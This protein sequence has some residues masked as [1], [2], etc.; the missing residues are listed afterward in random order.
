[1]KDRDAIPGC[2]QSGPRAFLKGAFDRA[3]AAV[4]ILL[5]LLPMVVVAAC[6]RIFMGSPV[7]FCNPRAGRWGKTFVLWKFKTMRDDRDASGEL[8]SDQERL[9]RLGR[10]LRSASLD[11]L[12]QLWNVLRGDMSLVGPR[13]LLLQYLPLYSEQQRR[14]HDVVPGITGWAQVNGRNA[15]SWEKK[16]ELDVW[17]VDHWSLLLDLRILFMTAK[18]V[19]LRTGISH[20]G[21]ATMPFFLGSA[22]SK[23]TNSQVDVS[24]ASMTEGDMKLRQS[25]AAGD[26]QALLLAACANGEEDR[27]SALYETIG[28]EPAWTA[29]CEHELESH[30]AHKLMQCHGAS[31]VPE[32]WRIAHEQVAARIGAYMS[33]L[34]EMAAALSAQGIPVIALK[35]AGIARGIYTCLGCSPMGDLDT[36]VRQSDFW[37]AHEI[38]LGLGYESNSRTRYNPDDAASGGLEYRRQVERAGSVWLELQWRSVAGR[39]IQRSQEPK[40]D[41]L[42]DRSIAIEGTKV[43]LL[44]HED[45]LLQVCLHTAK[46]SYLRAP[47]LRLHTD[48]ERIVR[49]TPIDWEVFLRMV[50]NLKVKTAV[51]FSL[52]LPFILLG[53]PIPSEVLKELEPSLARKRRIVR[54][55]QQAGLFYPHAG[56][57]FTRINYI[58]FNL[59]LYD[60]ASSLMRAVF[61]DRDSMKDRYGASNAISL[62]FQHAKRLADLCFRRT[63]I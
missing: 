17:Y 21:E 26:V 14:R 36:L 53:T 47:G 22:G 16:F 31:S 7:F 24:G 13:P 43:R 46:H 39:W 9:T 35:N 3:F 15:L 61:P 23:G 18:C 62:P 25:L 34:D 4:A 12:P 48:V 41:D 52:W 20:R 42:F 54:H 38:L 29:A 10:L 6:I 50:R 40:T 57:K 32:R 45:N 19:V 60:D 58:L 5:M 59:L 11:E 27:V 55:I 30:V 8:L 56:Q 1:M 28:D 63:G 51:Y 49:G 44:G 2:R 37:R 33:L